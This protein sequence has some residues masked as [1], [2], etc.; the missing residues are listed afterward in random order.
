[1][2]NVVLFLISASLSQ[3][4]TLAPPGSI[5]P[6]RFIIQLDTGIS[7]EDLAEELENEIDGFKKGH[8]FS[9]VLNGFSVEILAETKEEI[10]DV[11]SKLKGDFRIF[12][13]EPDRVV[14]IP[15]PVDRSGA[16]A[17]SPVIQRSAAGGI[18]STA[19]VGQIIPNGIKRIKAYPGP[20]GFGINIAIIDT[21]IA[22]N[23]P[24]LQANI[25]GNVAFLN[26]NGI[27]APGSAAGNDDNGHGTHVA[28]IAA[29][30]DN[31]IDVVG[32]APEANLWAVKVL[33]AD[34][35]GQL[36]DVIAGINYVAENGNIHVANMSL[37]IFDPFPSI[38]MPSP[39]CTAIENATA[40]GVTF[41][42][43]AGN[44]GWPWPADFF[45]PG[46]C[47]G[48]ITVSA[49][50][51]TDG[52]PGGLGP[53]SSFLEPDDTFAFF[54]NGDA[55]V[56]I[57]APGV[58]IESTWIVGQ[59]T[60]SGTSM[61]APHVTGAAALYLQANPEATPAEVKA[62]LIESAFPQH[63]PEG[64]SGDP[65][66]SHPPSPIP[67]PAFDEPLVNAAGAGRSGGVPP[68]VNVS[69]LATARDI[70]AGRDYRIKATLLNNDTENTINGTAFCT[71]LVSATVSESCGS[72]VS[73]SI[74]PGGR[75]DVSF[76]GPSTLD[77]GSHQARVSIKGNS[78]PAG[79]VTFF[80]N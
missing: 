51:D 21:G 3:A 17:G 35:T 48:V 38:G 24:D 37:S 53:P 49:I 54:S 7:P 14:A 44:W 79:T 43:A 70:R 47:P 6:G 46:N 27:M 60:I 26:G 71:V 8:V 63:G 39:L 68:V 20:G 65:D 10:E 28:G 11:L 15:E 19:L 52:L 66:H 75:A 40:A 78:A 55:A 42:A 13:I 74:P 34:G 80:I 4:K 50:T 73:V 62:G 45:S 29:A 5:I 9:S 41:V 31:G 69:V 64:F 22:L 67:D 33:G 76:K 61:A 59:K 30:M 57:A 1:M 32:V 2:I 25:Q 56:D 72:E 36:S 58:D 12:S 16:A 77:V 23:H 18:G